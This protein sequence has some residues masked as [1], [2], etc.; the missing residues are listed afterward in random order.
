[1]SIKFGGS[2]DDIKA[3]L[4][5]HGIDGDWSEID[6][7]GHRF[8]RK[9]GGVLTWWP[10]KG[11]VLCQGKPDE[12]AYLEELFS[13]DEAP[14]IEG[15]PPEKIQFEARGRIFIVHGHDTQARDQL[16]LALRRLDL[17]PYILMNQSGGGM[18]IIEALEGQIGKHPSSSFG[19]VLMTPDDMGYSKA[20]GPD[21]S[22]SRARQ[23]VIL[24]TGM[25]L[26]SLTRKRMAILVKGHVEIPS[27][28][29]GIIRYEYNEHIKE[30]FPKLAKRL[31]E[32]GFEVDQI[33]AATQ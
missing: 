10:S 14:D 31:G 5:K 26:A 21:E 12:K 13:H 16:E 1:M 17:E 25:L 6:H 20:D 19:I 8:R 30:V 29:E 33:A 28:L 2:L 3:L 23:N 24:E 18:T 15:S 27:D 11:T 22:K 9:N 7:G 32:S 4:Q